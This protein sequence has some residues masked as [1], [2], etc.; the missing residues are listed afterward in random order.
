MNFV[1]ATKNKHKI[2]EINSLLGNDKAVKSLSELGIEEELPETGRTLEENAL[3]KARY[4]YKQLGINCFADDTGLEIEALNGAPG[5]FS[6]RYAG[7]DKNSKKN[8]QK[9]L[10]ELKNTQNRKARFR[11]IIALIFDNK[12]MLFEGTVNG[13]ILEEPRGLSGFGYD[14]IFQPDGYD[15]SFAEMSMAEKNKMSHRAFALQQ[16]VDFMR[17]SKFI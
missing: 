17:I 10:L 3:Q 1:F 13:V 2:L 7:S 11:T 9:V 14:P 4:I 16:L 15:L 6:A 8:M 5:V 12:E